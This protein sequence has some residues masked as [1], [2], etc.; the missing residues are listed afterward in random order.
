MQDS[1]SISKPWLLQ[2]DTVGRDDHF[3]H[4]GG[5]SLLATRMQAR[6]LA[7]TGLAFQMSAF[8][9]SPTISGLVAG[10]ARDDIARAV[11]DAAAPVAP[12]VGTHREAG[13]KSIRN[14][15]VTGA[16]GFVGIHLLSELTRQL[17][18]VFCLQRCDTARAGHA[19][20]EREARTAG[21]A[22]DFTHMEVV[23]ADLTLPQAGLSDAD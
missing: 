15:I 1:V 18:R 10:A 7:R 3:F 2:I 9:R 21:L 8:Y 16:S 4:A 12:D 13:A 22:I 14:V 20:L 17:D 11:A 6:V 23:Q 19:R 5:N